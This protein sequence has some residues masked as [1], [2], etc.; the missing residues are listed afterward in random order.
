VAAT[1]GYARPRLALLE[2]LRDDAA[3]RGELA[4]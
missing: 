2:E 4:P 1:R 3:D